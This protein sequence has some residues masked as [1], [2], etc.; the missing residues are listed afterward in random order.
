MAKTILREGYT[1]L[2]TFTYGLDFGSFTENDNGERV[3]SIHGDFHDA[4]LEM[5]DHYKSLVQAAKDGDMEDFGYDCEIAFVHEFSDGTTVAYDK[6]KRETC[7]T[8]KE[9][10]Q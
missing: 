1:M 7:L 2:T 8:T 6:F 10:L 3:V 4:H 5:L 9:D